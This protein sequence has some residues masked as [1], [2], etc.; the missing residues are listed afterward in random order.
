MKKMVWKWMKKN[1][2]LPSLCSKQIQSFFRCYWDRREM[3]LKVWW[4]VVLVQRYTFQSYVSLY[5][6]EQKDCFL[7]YKSET[8]INFLIINP[9]RL[10]PFGR[11][12]QLKVTCSLTWQKYGLVCLKN[13]LVE[14]AFS[15]V[16][17]FLDIKSPQLCQVSAY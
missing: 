3:E 6:F 5:L 8:S 14:N 17:Y 7:L 4:S 2:M 15:S 16:T 12:A 11:M 10:G 1:I 9:N 13:G